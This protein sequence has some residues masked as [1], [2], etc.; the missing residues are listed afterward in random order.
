MKVKDFLEWFDNVDP[1][2]ELKFQSHEEI[3]NGFNGDSREI[4]TELHAFD[5][6]EDDKKCFILFDVGFEVGE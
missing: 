6:R 4:Y 2:M 5:M 3:I 1:G